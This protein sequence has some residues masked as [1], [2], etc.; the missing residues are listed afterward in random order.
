[1]RLSRIGTSIFLSG[2]LLGVA[3]TVVGATVR[4]S[5]IFTDVQPG[6]YYDEAIG[7]LYDDGVIKGLGGGKFGPNDYVTRGQVAVMMQR[8]KHELQGTVEQEEESSSSRSR[9]SSFSSSSSSTSSSSVSSRPAAGSF[10][11]TS[12][13]MS[14]VENIKIL[15][16]SIVRVGGAKGQ[17]TVDYA[18]SPGTATVNSDYTPISGTLVFADG[19]TSKT[20]TVSIVDDSVAEGPETIN[21]ALT[22]PTGGATLDTPS[23]AVITITDNETGGSSSSTAAASSNSS[24]PGTIEYA[25]TG[26]AVAENGGTLTVTVSRTGGSAGS[27]S[28]TYATQNGTAVSGTEYTATTGTVSFAAGETSKTFTV[29]IINNSSIEGAKKFTLTLSAPTGGATLGAAATVTIQDD[30]TSG[31]EFGSGSLKFSTATMTVKEGDHA[32]VTVNRVGGTNNVISVR[33]ETYSSGLAA[34]SDYTTTNGT[35]TFQPGESSKIIRIPTMKDSVSD[36]GEDFTVN[37]LNPSS[38]ISILSPYSMVIT[39][40]Q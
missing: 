21:F 11:F 5:S 3:G 7:E 19:A 9:S 25:A 1:M 18:L 34:A 23:T 22:N 32:V 35:L 16:V 6:A 17:A 30:D 8:L 36:P 39:I 40:D 33:Y 24:G 29:P 27:V 14:I 31:F 12:G 26:Y 4:G 28:A 10:R 13:T 20:L 15:T 37:L 38:G 2:V